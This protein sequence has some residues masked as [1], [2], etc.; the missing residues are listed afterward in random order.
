MSWWATLLRLLRIREDARADFVAI[1]NAVQRQLDGL[2]AR[3]ERAEA[4]GDANRAKVEE[5]RGEVWTLRGEN[6]ELR[7][8]LAQCESRHDS[9]QVRIQDLE[10]S[11]QSLGAQLAEINA[12]GEKP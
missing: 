6:T 8:K 3:L 9:D 10:T 12:R 11:C 2:T 5:L 1:N 7:E 4:T